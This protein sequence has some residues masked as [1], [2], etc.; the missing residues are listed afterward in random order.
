MSVRR[1]CQYGS[2]IDSY[3]VELHDGRRFKITGVERAVIGAQWRDR[4]EHVEINRDES[5]LCTIAP[6]DVGGW[7]NQHHEN[8]NGHCVIDV[9][10]DDGGYQVA[11]S[12]EEIKRIS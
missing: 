5:D 10:D 9:G 1:I 6:S 8:D 3:A 2:T 4:I 11:L 7:Y 12:V